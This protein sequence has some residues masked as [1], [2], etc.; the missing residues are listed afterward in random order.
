[1]P[2]GPPVAGRQSQENLEI[3]Q[4]SGLQRIN[5]H[6]AVDLETGQ[7][8]IEVETVDAASTIRLLE[9]IEAFYPNPGPHPG[10]FRQRALSSRDDRA[11]MA[12]SAGATNNA[13][14]HPALLPASEPDRTA[15]GR[16]AQA[17]H[18]Q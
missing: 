5:I 8:E 3:E 15:M 12:R 6:G 14:L 9:S 17:C 18:A 2:R 16:D 7:P 11:R 13:A 10:F 1:M 4:T